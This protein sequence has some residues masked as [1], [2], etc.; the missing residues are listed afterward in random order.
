MQTVIRVLNKFKHMIKFSIVSISQTLESSPLQCALQKNLLILCL[1][2]TVICPAKV[3]SAYVILERMSQSNI[4]VSACNERF[5]IHFSETRGLLLDVTLPIMCA[6]HSRC[7][8]SW[9]SKK[10]RTSFLSLRI[11]KVKNMLHI[12]RSASTKHHCCKH[13]YRTCVCFGAPSSQQLL[14][15]S[16]EHVYTRLDTILDRVVQQKRSSIRTAQE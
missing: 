12:P 7:S 3:R 11:F 9:C 14:L 5:C 16:V 8:S 2:L 15:V 13:E 1:S 4:I 10:L 6:M